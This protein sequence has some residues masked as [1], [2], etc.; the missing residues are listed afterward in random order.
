[1]GSVDTMAGWPLLI[2]KAV[3]AP[4]SWIDGALT[5]LSYQHLVFFPGQQFGL[6]TRRS[7]ILA[8]TEQGFL[9]ADK[10]R[11]M[12]ISFREVITCKHLNILLQGKF[13]I[14]TDDHIYKVDYNLTKDSLVVP[15]IKAYR[16]YLLAHTKK[17]TIDDGL[18]KVLL[19]GEGSTRKMLFHKNLKMYNFLMQLLPEEQENELIYY[20]KSTE[21][22]GLKAQFQ[23]RHYF[24]PYLIIKT[25]HEMILFNQESHV[26]KNPN[27][28]GMQM[29]H[30]AWDESIR[31]SLDDHHASGVLRILKGSRTLFKL[32]VKKESLKLASQYCFIMNRT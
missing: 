4:E 13:M 28:Y 6:F 19:E 9:Y 32:H 18:T 10:T 2:T 7:V 15:F 24:T 12:V 11:R 21:Q 23:S 20:Q 22:V 16:D 17:F 1:M 31:F 8:L 14:V 27:D 30:I 25:E 3:K 26:S 29:N 5:G